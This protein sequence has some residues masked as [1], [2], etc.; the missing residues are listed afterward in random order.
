MNNSEAS[1]AVLFVNNGVGFKT[2]FTETKGNSPHEGWGTALK[3]AN[4]P[5]CVARKPLVKSQL[6]KMY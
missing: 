3:P 1:E 6:L 4:E 5:I 2:Y